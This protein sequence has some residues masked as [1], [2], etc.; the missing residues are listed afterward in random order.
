MYNAPES[1]INTPTVLP[2]AVAGICREIGEK[3]KK[4]RSWEIGDRRSGEEKKKK[5]K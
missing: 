5:K 3:K 2:A 1:I 4:K